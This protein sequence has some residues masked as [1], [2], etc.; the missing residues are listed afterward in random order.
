M[1][2]L[3][4]LLLAVIVLG[5][6]SFKYKKLYLYLC[7]ALFPVMPTY[8]AL[9]ITPS[10]PLITIGRVILLYTFLFTFL[11]V[12]KERYLETFSYLWKSKL[13]W[14]VVSI[15]VCKGISTAAAL[16]SVSAVKNYL[17]FGVEQMALV[18]FLSLSIDSKECIDRI[19]KIL[20]GT[21]MI[22]V[23]CAVIESF[24][25]YNAFWVFTPEFERNYVS[26]VSYV[27]LG[28]VRA[29][30]PFEHPI[31][32]AL[33]TLFIYSIALYKF[34]TSE[35]YV[36][37]GG[38]AAALLLMELLTVSRFPIMCLIL[39][40]LLF[41]IF[42]NR[43]Q[44][45]RIGKFIAIIAGFIIIVFPLKSTIF[46]ATLY[47][48]IASLLDCTVGKVM[49][50]DFVEAVETILPKV[51]EVSSGGF[52][53]LGGLESEI[54]N[55]VADF[56]TNTNPYI[57]RFFLYD[58]AYDILKKHP[59]F[60]LG[61]AYF[62]NHYYDISHIAN[63]TFRKLRSVDNAYL[64]LLVTEGIVSFV[65][66]IPYY[67]FILGVNLKNWRDSKEITLNKMFAILLFCYYIAL[68]SSGMLGTIRIL[69]VI[70][71]VIFGNQ[72]LEY[73][74]KC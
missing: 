18:L 74:K 5:T 56:G 7:V 26:H 49:G 17:S 54:Q 41:L 59:L 64:Y 73:K 43:T 24:T 21:S 72:I 48:I 3:I 70:I 37:Y 69:C 57:Y 11:S 20:V 68:L 35:K 63:A 33:Y 66:T 58:V 55:T 30:G 9:E 61:G 2:K 22:I 12:K 39:V 34:L 16:P 15:V 71:A 67:I 23:I 13:V 8:W 51:Q 28:I 1:I 38:M 4:F 32:L 45:V 62:Q 50:I 46:V 6:F 10:F 47:R 42:G 44:R 14:V 27:R 52:N 36:R 25:G 29:S 53:V 31:A 65:G 40:T 19:L 60:G